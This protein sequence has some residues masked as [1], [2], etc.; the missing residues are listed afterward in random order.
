M[1]FEESMKL[2]VGS[3][4]KALYPYLHPVSSAS[5]VPTYTVLRFMSSVPHQ[6]FHS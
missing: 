1:K 4:E 5:S 3:R 6:M 2:E